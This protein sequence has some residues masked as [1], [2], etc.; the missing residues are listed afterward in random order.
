VAQGEGPE[1]NLQYHT[2]KKKKRKKKEK[3]MEA[4]ATNMVSLPVTQACHI[5]TRK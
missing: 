1:F 4:K 5:Q 2:K 3:K